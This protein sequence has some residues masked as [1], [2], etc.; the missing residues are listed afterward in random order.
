MESRIHRFPKTS[1][2]GGRNSFAAIRTGGLKFSRGPLNVWALPNSLDHG[3]LGISIGRHVGIAVRRNRI[4]RL[5]R[6]AYRLMQHDLPASY[7]WL[8]VVKRHEPMILGEYQK[9]LSAATAHLHNAWLER[10]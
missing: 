2:L 3:R 1:R 6:E 5:L 4:K 7:D 9:L 8:V 10:K